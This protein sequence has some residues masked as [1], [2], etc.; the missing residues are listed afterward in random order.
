MSGSKYFER[1]AWGITALVLAVTILFMSG[2]W[3]GIA[4][5]ERTMGYESRLFDA[6]KVHSIDILMDDWDT[7]IANA[8]S[9]E[10]YAANV[11]IDGEAYKNVG[12]RA[13]GNT[14]LSTVASLGSERYSFK[15]EFD[16]YDSTKS[17]Y[18]LDKLSLNN[19][20]QDSTMM[21]DYLVYTMMNEFGVNSSLCSYV[22]ITVNGEDW[23]LYVAVEGVEEAFLERNYG[24]NYGELYKPDSMSFGGGRGNG[25]DFDINDLDFDF[26]GNS[27][28]DSES[29]DAAGGWDPSAIFGGGQPPNMPSDMP[30]F[31]GSETG[32]GGSPAGIPEDFD[33]SEMVGGGGFSFGMGSSDVKL[34]YI[35]DELD[36]YS[37]IWNN[38]KTDITEAD[39][40]RLIASLKKL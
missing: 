11:V 19:L 4:A 31:E 13:K 25:G 33:P 14:S 30:S 40:R 21:K 38:A 3:I 10:Y 8:T 37:N 39:Q 7:F 36:S 22:Y 9:E 2:N 15:I 32:D 26:G 24:S 28:G 23:G 1:V 16:H 29:G 18:G 6:T 35:D 20:I 5:M 27:Q 17:Y 34:Q 12:I